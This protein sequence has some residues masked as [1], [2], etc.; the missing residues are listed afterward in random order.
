[1]HLP[2]RVALVGLAPLVRDV[3]HNLITG[4]SDMRVAAVIETV[5]E[6]HGAPV[7]VYLL[8]VET[9][10]ESASE[11]LLG[12]APPPY[13]VIGVSADGRQMQLS[14]LRPATA[15]LGSLSSHELLEVIRR[16]NRHAVGSVD[17]S[18]NRGV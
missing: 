13:R 15:S 9:S 18:F 3:L 8:G 16:G 10:A 17:P 11:R 4:E 7:D 6:L 1:M 2:I 12:Q 5:D 14:E